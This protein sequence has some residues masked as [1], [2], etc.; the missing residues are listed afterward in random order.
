MLPSTLADILWCYS[1]FDPDTYSWMPA[2]IAP[3]LLNQTDK[4]SAGSLV[5]LAQGLS[6][7]DFYNMSLY[8]N[9]AT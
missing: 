7:F 4:L 1:K 5:R 3:S 8:D 6:R 9:I 2:H